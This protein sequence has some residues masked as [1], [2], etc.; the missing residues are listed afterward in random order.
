[1]TFR[2]FLLVCSLSFHPLIRVCLNFFHLFYFGCAESLLLQGLFSSCRGGY[3]L[4]A[5][6]GFLILMAS[7]A[8][9]Q[10]L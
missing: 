3:S 2:Y 10:G 5:V 9:E 4:V 7:L 1:M 6:L 8:A